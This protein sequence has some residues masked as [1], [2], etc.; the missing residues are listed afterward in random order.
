MGKPQVVFTIESDK[1]LPS[2]VVAP[3]LDYL[4]SQVEPLGAQAYVSRDESDDENDE[5]D[6]DEEHEALN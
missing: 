5:G 6:G 3:L 1:E 2:S 4:R